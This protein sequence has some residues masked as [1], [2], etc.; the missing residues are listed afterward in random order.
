MSPCL[1]VFLFHQPVQGRTPQGGSPPVVS[2]GDDLPWPGQA[3]MPCVSSVSGRHSS[4][5]TA[6]VRLKC[7]I[8]AG[9]GLRRWR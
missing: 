2:G 1:G 8:L 7:S 9:E 3:S 4:L 5:Y 6:C